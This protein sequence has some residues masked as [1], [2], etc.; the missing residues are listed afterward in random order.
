MADRYQLRKVA[1]IYWLVD[2][3]QSGFEYKKPLPLNESAATIWT[4]LSSGMSK[5]EIAQEL[6]EGDD[7]LVEVIISDIDEF[8]EQ[9]NSAGVE[10]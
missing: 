6:S 3:L 9:L 2:V 5:R 8:I 4:M 10:W 7:S 1:G